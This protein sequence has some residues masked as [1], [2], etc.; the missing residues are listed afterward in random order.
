MQPT[1][2]LSV[3]SMKDYLMTFWETGKMRFNIASRDN[4]QMYCLMSLPPGGVQG[5]VDEAQT[6]IEE[7]KMKYKLCLNTFEDS[8]EQETRLLCIDEMRYLKQEYENALQV[9]AFGI[10]RINQFEK[11]RAKFLS[12]KGLTVDE[13]LYPED[14]ALIEEVINEVAAHDAFPEQHKWTLDFDALRIEEPIYPEPPGAPERE[15]EK[16]MEEPMTPTFIMEDPSTSQVDTIAT[17]L[18]DDDYPFRKAAS[19]TYEERRKRFPVPE[20]KPDPFWTAAAHRVAE[21]IT[22]KARERL[23]ASIQPKFEPPHQFFSSWDKAEVGDREY[24]VRTRQDS[25]PP[26]MEED[27]PSAAPTETD[28]FWSDELAWDADVLLQDCLVTTPAVGRTEPFNETELIWI[29]HLKEKAFDKMKFDCGHQ[30]CGACVECYE[31]YGKV[32]AVYEGVRHHLESV[33]E[34]LKDYPV[35]YDAYTVLIEHA[36]DND[37]KWCKNVESWR[38]DDEPCGKCRSCLIKA[39]ICLDERESVD[40]RVMDFRLALQWE[41]SYWMDRLN[42]EFPEVKGIYYE[43]RDANHKLFIPML[44]KLYIK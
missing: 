23:E 4:K 13:Q 43:D 35:S 28:N 36:R 3:E 17:F 40:Q 2:I 37:W 25:P 18:T 27:I 10:C 12:G 33:K 6:R 32:P 7:Y 14:I 1:P 29:S 42:P 38:E 34:K 26:Y 31:N 5:V 41:E 9:A 21:R 15:E 24:T 11:H 22:E 8:K 16:E 20:F 44:T 19:E 39:L 30:E